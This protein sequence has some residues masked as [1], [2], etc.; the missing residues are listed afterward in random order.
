MFAD[1][2]ALVADSP[3]T[4]Q[5]LLDTFVSE[6][7]KFGLKV[8]EAKT[9]VMIINAP[10]KE[11]HS[12]GK[13][14]KEVEHFKYLGSNIQSNGCIDKEINQRLFNASQAFQKLYHR[15]WKRH[16]IN[17]KTKLLVYNSI[18]LSTLLY[19]SETWTSK[20]TDIKKLNSFH[21]KCL[22]SILKLTWK[23]KIPNEEILKR[24]NMLSIENIIR[25]KRLRWAGHLSR[26]SENR[27][28]QQIIFGELKRG[29]R[30][31]KK[32]KLRWMDMLKKDLTEQNIGLQE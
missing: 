13:V 23:D 2:C 9:E 32:P 15:V 14:I 10:S 28:P 19:A 22:R 16:E 27:V 5:E 17:L 31:Q 8:N 1:D 29:E 21:T 4:L 11:I 26:M 30:P 24:S 20:K 25:V 3:E 7:E 6:T 12:K 18:V